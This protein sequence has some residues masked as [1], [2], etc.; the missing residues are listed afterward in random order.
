LRAKEEVGEAFPLRSA[1]IDLEASAE[2]PEHG[3]DGWS[4]ISDLSDVCLSDVSDD[5]QPSNWT[6]NTKENGSPGSSYRFTFGKCKGESVLER[7]PKDEYTTWMKNEHLPLQQGKEDLA[8]G[9]E[10]YH[11][12]QL[13]IFEKDHPDASMYLFESGQ[14]KSQCITDVP[15]WYIHQLEEEQGRFDIRLRNAI[16]WRIMLL[17]TNRWMWSVGKAWSQPKKKG[18]HRTEFQWYPKNL[19]PFLYPTT[20]P[21]ESMCGTG[22]TLVSVRCVPGGSREVLLSQ[23]KGPWISRDNGGKSRTT[24]CTMMDGGRCCG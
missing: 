16:K 1:A 22:N 23:R 6:K 3:L 7:S 12:D 8:Q 21:V 19:G 20:L 17:N 18:V 10:Y 9:I 5:Y 13:A 14:F 2:G 4:D 15:N 24:S 11:K